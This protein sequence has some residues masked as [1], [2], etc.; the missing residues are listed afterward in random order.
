MRN[1]AAVFYKQIKDTWKNK[2]V[3]IQ[4]LLFPVM[5]VVMN[6]A[7]KME[8]MTENFFTE[9]FAVMY[10]G[11]APLMSG[12]AIVSEEKENGTLRALFMAGV[13]P[14]E[15]L[16]G[17]GGYLWIAC[18][19]GSLIMVFSGNYTASQIPCF[20]LIMAVGIMISQMMGA[21]VGIMSSSQMAA[22]SMAI[23]IMMV[24]SFLPMLAMFNQTIGAVA[25][26]TY[27]QQL[28]TLLSSI[29]YGIV[30]ADNLWILGGNG[31]IVLLLF[32]FI[33]KKNGLE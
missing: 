4:F 10:I 21:C 6:R 24:F 16:F 12:A 26:Y 5:T 31:V 20:L 8:N 18:M 19:I 2:T 29:G 3:L 7:V 22:S 28:Q 1:A 13:K 25:K 32:L 15:Y 17:V 11:M 33:Y 9:L 14:S 27:T 23:P 30:S